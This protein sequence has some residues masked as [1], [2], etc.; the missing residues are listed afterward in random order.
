M[1]LMGWIVSTA[2]LSFIEH[3]GPPSVKGLV[4]NEVGWF[5]VVWYGVQACEIWIEGWGS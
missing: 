3:G 2:Y 5:G 1:I 4:E